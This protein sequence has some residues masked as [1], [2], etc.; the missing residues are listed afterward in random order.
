MGKLPKRNV[1][2]MKPQAKSSQGT[3]SVHSLVP[4]T[5]NSKKHMPV[6]T[7]A[8]QDKRRMMMTCN[9]TSTMN[10]ISVQMQHHIHLCLASKPL[11]S[12]GS[13]GIKPSKTKDVWKEFHVPWGAADDVNLGSHQSG[14]VADT[15]NFL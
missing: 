11:R 2:D 14:V 3:P 4:R 5:K 13:F 7:L 9:L 12:A 15:H 1:A 8:P 10:V 6:T